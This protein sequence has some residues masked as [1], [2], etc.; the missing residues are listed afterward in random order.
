MK[1]R[2]LADSRRRQIH[3][4]YGWRSPI[5]C[6]DV[7]EIFEYVIFSMSAP[8]TNLG[9]AGLFEGRRNAAESAKQLRLCEIRIRGD[10]CSANGLLA[11]FCRH[12][13]Y[14]LEDVCIA[15]GSARLGS[16]SFSRRWANKAVANSGSI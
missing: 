1:I 7:E 14:L 13:A 10:V 11:E 3:L 15:H 16:H 5:V 8:M 2:V 6:P 9:N 4:G 12:S